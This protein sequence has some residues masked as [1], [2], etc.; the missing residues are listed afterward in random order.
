MRDAIALH[1]D[2]MRL[3]GGGRTCAVVSDFDLLDNTSYARMTHFCLNKIF[4]FSR[5]ISVYAVRSTP[6]QIS[7]YQY[8][9]KIK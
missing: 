8:Y 6:E 4:F 5:P 2:S 9:K 7:K 3:S 1:Q